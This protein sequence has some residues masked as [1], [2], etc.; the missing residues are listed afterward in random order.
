MLLGAARVA[1][2]SPA[3]GDYSL[4]DVC[5]CKDHP[6]IG[7]FGSAQEYFSNPINL[8]FVEH[9]SSVLNRIFPVMG[10]YR[11]LKLQPCVCYHEHLTALQPQ[12]QEYSIN[13]ESG[14]S[15]FRI[16]FCLQ[17]LI[18]LISCNSYNLL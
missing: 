8:P 11:P 6:G 3:L 7:T 10:G 13:F 12:T 16:F 15:R 9:K 2:I 4:G 14:L 18:A 5:V 17:L 1:P